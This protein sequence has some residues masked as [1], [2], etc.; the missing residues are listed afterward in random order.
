MRTLKLMLF[1]RPAATFG[2]AAAFMILVAL[3]VNA[4]A[5]R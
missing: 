2:C 4:Q 5:L 3:I 1:Y